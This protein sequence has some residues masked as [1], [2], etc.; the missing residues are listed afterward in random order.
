MVN[1]YLG[2]NTLLAITFLVMLFVSI[3][4]LSKTY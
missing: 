4:E 3:Y 1:F 2:F